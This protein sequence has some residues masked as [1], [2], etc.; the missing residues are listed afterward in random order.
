MS[1]R[2]NEDER[3]ERERLG[4]GPIERVHIL[5]GGIP[6]RAY[7][8]WIRG[9]PPGVLSVMLMERVGKPEDAQRDPDMPFF[10]AG[11]LLEGVWGDW[12]RHP[13][14]GRPVLRLYTGPLPPLP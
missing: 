13:T 12:E 1:K 2:D 7:A 4:R 8:M 11:T 3:S 14:T 9:L 6:F 10:D 5:I